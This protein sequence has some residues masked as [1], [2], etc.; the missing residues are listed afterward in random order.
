MVIVQ[1]ANLVFFF[2]REYRSKYV[3]P[4]V[5]SVVYTQD[6][7]IRTGQSLHPYLVVGFTVMV[8]FSLLTVYIGAKYNDQVK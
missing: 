3:D 6:E 4:I 8:T 7:V 5:F 1:S 2:F